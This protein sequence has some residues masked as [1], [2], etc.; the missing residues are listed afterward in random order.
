MKIKKKTQANYLY[1]CINI[2]DDNVPLAPHTYINCIKIVTAFSLISLISFIFPKNVVEIVAKY[3]STLRSH[4]IRLRL[5]FLIFGNKSNG[6]KFNL[7]SHL[8]FKQ[9]KCH[10]AKKKTERDGERFNSTQHNF[11]QL[12]NFF[13]FLIVDEAVEC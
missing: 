8:R 10:K 13:G 4:S 3:L 11:I 6:N 7:S 1:Q 2:G 9:K 12:H 5:N